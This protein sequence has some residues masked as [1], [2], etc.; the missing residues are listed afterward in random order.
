M[1]TNFFRNSKG[2]IFFALMLITGTIIAQQTWTSTTSGLYHISATCSTSGGATGAPP[3]SLLAD[4]R[5]IITNGHMVTSVASGSFIVNMGDN[6]QTKPA[7]LK[8]YGLV[9]DL[10]KNYSVPVYW[11]INPGKVKNGTDFT[12]NGVAHKGFTFVIDK[13]YITAA[14]ATAISQWTSSTVGSGKGLVVGA[15]TTSSLTVNVS[16][17]FTAVPNWTLDAQNGSIAAGFFTNAGIPAACDASSH[18]GF[19][20][21]LCANIGEYLSTRTNILRSINFFN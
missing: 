5:V 4:Q 9:Y 19:Q 2:F 1:Q 21:S 8:P 12:Y 6:A 14:V 18:W 7:G 10:I 11:V 15:Y 3:L 17:R 13:K 20:E 16:S